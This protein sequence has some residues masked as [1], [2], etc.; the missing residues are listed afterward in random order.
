MSLVLS[1]L[2]VLGVFA[3]LGLVAWASVIRVS[4]SSRAARPSF[5][6]VPMVASYEVLGQRAA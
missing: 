6:Q 4:A 5:L 2:L 1:I 3:L